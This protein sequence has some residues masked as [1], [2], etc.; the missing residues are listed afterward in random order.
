MTNPAP[1][2]EL[3][4]ST[5]VI[6]TMPAKL[7]PIDICVTIKNVAASPTSNAAGVVRQNDDAVIFRR[8][9][10][11]IRDFGNKPN[12]HDLAIN[13]ITVC[14]W[15][16]WDTGVRIVGALHTIGLHRA[17]VVQVLA[18]NNGADPDR[19]RWHLTEDHRYRLHPDNDANDNPH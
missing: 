16:G 1:D 2:M 11:M 9:R 6:R 4:A 3:P 10:A 5:P 13:L 12:K 18:E 17:H 7:S 14:I 8:M 15:E 19:Y